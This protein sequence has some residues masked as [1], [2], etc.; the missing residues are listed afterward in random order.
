MVLE[1][2]A[3]DKTKSILQEINSVFDMIPNFF[4]AQ[5]AADPDWLELNWTR[6]KSIMG[7]QRDLEGKLK[8]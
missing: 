6:W 7:R 2:G 5:A 1:N 4:S 3:T 8:S